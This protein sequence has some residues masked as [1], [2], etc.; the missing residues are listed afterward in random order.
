MLLLLLR[1]PLPERRRL[2]R[3]PHAAGRIRPRGLRPHE[4]RPSIR[5]ARTR[6][7]CCAARARGASTAT[8]HQSTPP[9][10]VRWP[11]A[12]VRRPPPAPSLLPRPRGAPARGPAPSS[13]PPPLLDGS[14]PARL[15]RGSRRRCA[16][17]RRRRH[18]SS[19]SSSN[20]H[21]NRRSTSAARA[22][23]RAARADL[24]ARWCAALVGLYPCGRRCRLVAR[25]CLWCRR[26]PVCL[27]GRWCS[28]RRRD[29]CAR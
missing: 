11:P 13:P 9:P 12:L 17:R 7:A 26:A 14:R 28:R 21:H 1:S 22:C 23:P 3:R 18:R 5:A 16:R 4:R 20:H 27:C 10:A 24:C 8:S 19:S 2:S 6:G 15:Q 29:R 25:V